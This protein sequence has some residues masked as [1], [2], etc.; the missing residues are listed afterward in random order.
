VL[1]IGVGDIDRE[2]RQLPLVQYRHQA[3]GNNV[4]VEDVAGL[5]EY[6]MAVQCSCP[7]DLAIVRLEQAMNRH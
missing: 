2:L 1:S 3:T 6:S 4:V 7:E 5:H